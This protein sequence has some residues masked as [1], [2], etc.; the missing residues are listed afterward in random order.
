MQRSCAYIGARTLVLV[1][2]NRMSGGKLYLPI[3]ASLSTC[4]VPCHHLCSSETIARCGGSGN[5]RD[6]GTNIGIGMGSRPVGL[7]L[8]WIYPCQEWDQ[9][10]SCGPG[11]DNG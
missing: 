6:G 8:A 10:H 11:M 2:L 4:Y 7:L 1:V 3:M 5:M 9:V